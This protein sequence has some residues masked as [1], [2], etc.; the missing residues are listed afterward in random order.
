MKR[1]IVLVSA[2]AMAVPVVAFNTSLT[3]GDRVG[4]L[5]PAVAYEDDAD[6]A[7]LVSSYLTA[8]LRDR[9]LDAFDA[10][11]GFA[12]LSV[13]GR[14]DADYYVEVV[15]GDGDSQ[16][17]GGVGVGSRSVGVDVALVVSRIATKM[18]VY[19]GKTLE[20]V[21][22]YDLQRRSTTLMPTSIG[23]GGR[24]LGLWVALPF[25]QYA[26]YRSAAR[27]VAYDAAQKIAVETVRQ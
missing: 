21:D 24:H 15:G 23:I 1:L 14:V 17:Y 8:A 20:L 13:D 7:R 9:G 5:R 18:R 26:R 16:P 27:A 10:R 3:R 22:E 4:V 19:S 12:D 25:V 2:L 6:V 11:L